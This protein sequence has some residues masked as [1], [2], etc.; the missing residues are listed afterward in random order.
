MWKSFF[1]LVRQ[2]L[3]LN[4]RVK[5]NQE[6][7]AELRD[8]VRDLAHTAE[9][10]DQHLQ[11]QIERLVYE[12]KRLESEL[13]HS[14]EREADARERLRLELENKM[15]REK[16]LPPAANGNDKDDDSER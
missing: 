1:D 3:L 4:D 11:R 5:R 13:Q 7:L 15:L 16:R 14:R 9:E 10:G 6:G 12:L 8:E 2:V